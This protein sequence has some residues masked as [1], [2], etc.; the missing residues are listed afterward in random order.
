MSIDAL[1][2]RTYDRKRYN[3]AHFV[4]DA[5]KHETGQDIRE[6]L[7]GFLFPPSDRFVLFALR[8]SFVSLDRPKSPCIVLMRSPRRE[9]HVGI[10]L[11]GKVLHITQSGPQLQPLDIATLGFSIV[12]F[13]ACSE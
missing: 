12:R 8:H 2:H 1:L 10:W 5:W 9:P 6:Q 3:C 4:S 11:R 7:I 13:Y